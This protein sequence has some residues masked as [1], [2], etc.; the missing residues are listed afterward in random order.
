MYMCIVGHGYTTKIVP[1]DH[2]VKMKENEKIDIC[3]RTEKAVE[4]EGDGNANC[5]RRTWNGPVILEK[6]LV[7]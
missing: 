1:G 6:R 2:S 7:K 5:S 4:H 3:L